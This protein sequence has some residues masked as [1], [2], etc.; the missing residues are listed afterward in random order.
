MGLKQAPHSV[1]IGLG[2]RS[3]FFK[4]LDSP[5]ACNMHTTKSTAFPSTRIAARRGRPAG[6]HRR[7]HVASVGRSVIQA[8]SK[9]PAAVDLHAPR[10]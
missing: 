9:A 2:G 8:S 5:I 7:Q 6:H 10:R 1:T 4:D 3:E